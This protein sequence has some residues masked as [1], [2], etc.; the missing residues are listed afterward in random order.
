MQANDEPYLQEVIEKASNEEF[1]LS[2]HMFN[3]SGEIALAL[4]TSE[5]SIQ[6]MIE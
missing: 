5:T 3:S 1:I 4:Q 6:V 2:E